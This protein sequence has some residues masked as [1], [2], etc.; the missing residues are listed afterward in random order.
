MSPRVKKYGLI[1]FDLCLAVYLV[2]AFSA[3][4]KPDESLHVCKDVQVVV[5]DATA[6]GFIDADEVVAR[7][8]KAKLY[9]KGMPLAKISCRKIE[10]TLVRTPFVKT[11]ECYKNQDGVVNVSITQRMPVVRIKAI[12]NDD[13]YVDDQDCIMPN[14][15]YTS[16]LIIATG[17][18]SRQYATGYVSPMARALAE[19]D[20]YRNLFEQINITRKM[21]VELIPRIGDHSVFLGRLPQ[22][23]IKQER[24]AMIR[25]FIQKKL[26]RLELFYKYGLP[27]AGWNKYSEINL[28]FDNQI[29]CKRRYT[30]DD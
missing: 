12:N 8:R 13:F 19:N 24:D 7:L 28:E 27:V 30:E 9:P 11:A 17:F 5:A 14:S 25:E 3:F 15:H 10:E 26:H 1:F 20:L 22:S 6:N 29:I 23:N 21:E 16:D 18:I 2:L 4:N